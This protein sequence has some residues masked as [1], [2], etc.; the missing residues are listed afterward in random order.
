MKLIAQ[1]C[2]KNLADAEKLIARLD[3][4]HRALEPHRGAKT[5][6]W[7]LGH[8]ATTGDFARR[9]CGGRPICPPAWRD[10]FKPGTQPST[11]PDDYPTMSELGEAVRNVYG[12]LATRIPEVEPAVFAASNPYEVARARFPTTGE[13]VAYLASS[14]L[15]YHVGQLSTWCAV[16]DLSG[17]RVES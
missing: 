3:D 14:H 7:L 11:N 4:S 9:L 2:R 12:D 17:A 8:L 13:F 5:A 1:Q 15:A 16:A 6:G 10:T